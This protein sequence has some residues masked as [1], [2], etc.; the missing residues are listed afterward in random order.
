[1]RL[2]YDTKSSIQLRKLPSNCEQFHDCITMPTPS[3]RV[4]FGCITTKG[5]EEGVG[6]DVDRRRLPPELSD[7]CVLVKRD[8]LQ[9]WMA[10]QVRVPVQRASFP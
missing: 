2:S 3:T 9:I 10:E 5:S 1:M 6:H 8:P 4:N 7:D